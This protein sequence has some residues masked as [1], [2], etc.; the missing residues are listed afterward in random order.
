MKT[1]EDVINGL[2]T[3]CEQWCH[4][5]LLDTNRWSYLPKVPSVSFEV[6]QNQEKHIIIR[7][8]V[9]HDPFGYSTHVEE[10][11]HLS[12]TYIDMED[13]TN[14]LFSAL[15]WKGSPYHIVS[16]L[17]E[18]P[19]KKSKSKIRFLTYRWRFEKSAEIMG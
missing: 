1:V 7:I 16:Y 18:Q 10:R 19:K 11:T 3:V 2:W 12:I 5:R 17:D 15:T 13:L 9:R 6:S 8:K 14:Q 4:P